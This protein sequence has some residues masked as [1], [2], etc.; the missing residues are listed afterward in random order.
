VTRRQQVISLLTCA[1]LY[2]SFAQAQQKCG[3]SV[4]CQCGDTV[5]AD[6]TFTADLGPCAEGLTVA[7]GVT[8]NGG[9][10][11]LA[12]SGEGTGLNFDATQGSQVGYLHVT[13]FDR[14]IWMHSGSSGNLYHD[15][16]TWN[17]R[18]GM[19]IHPSAGPNN[20]VW[21]V[22]SLLNREDG[23]RLDGATGQTVAYSIAW[24]NETSL[25]LDRTNSNTIW[26]SEFYGDMGR[27]TN[28]RDGH[29]NA[30]YWSRFVLGDCVFDASFEDNTWYQDV[31][32]CRVIQQET[33]A[34]Q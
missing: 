29:H 8:V 19:E 34:S 33:V 5:V 6:Y 4:P 3:G 12:G 22:Y 21:G 23:I 16:W 18:K 17:S 32:D 2:A 31:M 30:V 9:G 27:A 1:T 11:W 20:W 25:D 26:G 28:M 24:S 10:H 15:S 7:S 14:N 13:G